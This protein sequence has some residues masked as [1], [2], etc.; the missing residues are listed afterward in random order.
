MD[1][2]LVVG[3]FVL[4]AVL[5]VFAVALLGWGMWPRHSVAAEVHAWLERNSQAQRPE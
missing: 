4:A 5:L 1:L 2:I 3:S